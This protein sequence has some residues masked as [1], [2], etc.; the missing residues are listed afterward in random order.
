MTNQ[1]RLTQKFIL[2]CI[3]SYSNKKL[4]LCEITGLIS[5]NYFMTLFLGDG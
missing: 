2:L 5:K 3:V 4:L 1:T